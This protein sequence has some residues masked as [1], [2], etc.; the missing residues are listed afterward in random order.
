[1]EKCAKQRLRAWE[2]RWGAYVPVLIEEATHSFQ[3]FYSGGK[4]TWYGSDPWQ[5]RCFLTAENVKHK[6]RP[7]ASIKIRKTLVQRFVKG[8]PIN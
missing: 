4:R 1:M 2:G 6:I 3:G 5:G 7:D 8:R